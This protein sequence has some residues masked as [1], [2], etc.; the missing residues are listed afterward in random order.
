MNVL[1]E[2]DIKNEEEE[3]ISRDYGFRANLRV[4]VMTLQT[5]IDFLEKIFSIRYNM[6]W[7]RF[8]LFIGELFVLWAFV[9]L[10]LS[11]Y[12]KAFP[13]I[14]LWTILLAADV[15]FLLSYHAFLLPSG[16][17]LFFSVWSYIFGV[18][19]Y[20]AIKWGFV[21][22]STK[23]QIHKTDKNGVIEFTKGG[24]GYLLLMDGM[25]SATAMS[26]EIKALERRS[27][28]YQN[29]RNRTT[30]EFNITSSKRQDMTDQIKSNKTLKKETDNKAFKSV[31]NTRIMQ[32][33]S[34]LDGKYS[35]L[36][37]H[38][39]LRDN[40][41][42]ELNNRVDTIK[43]YTSDGG[44][45]FYGAEVLGKKEVDEFFKNFYSFK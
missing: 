7:K 42:R 12:P 14:G 24:Y 5:R 11:A 34:D 8:W 29:A 16:G 6:T 10:I 36:I 20:L 35:T 4:G 37:Q 27:K 33:E 30:T 32:Y 31:I 41:L 19:K 15:S 18:F 39:L 3:S 21:N 17:S 25:S 1:A 40:S 23:T 2:N 45:L 26:K 9:G 22:P 43:R 28:S 38:K 44:G 13:Y